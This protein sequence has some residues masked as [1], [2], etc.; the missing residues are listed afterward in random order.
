MYE[1]VWHQYCDWYVEHSKDTLYGADA[2]RKA[3]TLNVMHYV[4]STSLR[5]LHPIMPFITE[6][7]W[8]A[9]GY[10]GERDTIMLAP[11]P[12]ALDEESLGRWGIDRRTGSSQRTMAGCPVQPAPPP[13]FGV[14]ASVLK[15]QATSSVRFATRRS[16]KAPPSRRG[17]PRKVITP[18]TPA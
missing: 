14:P 1:F 6:E 7:L 3:Q 12:A 16:P 9:M 11:W 2:A 10:G 4:F 18:S 17:P 5:L 15:V 13:H 8:H